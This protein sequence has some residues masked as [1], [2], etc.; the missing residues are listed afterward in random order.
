MSTI[1]SFE[2]I[3]SWQKA[4][5]LNK[6]IYLLSGKDMFNKDYALKDQI[7]RASI[8][9]LS[10]IAEGFERN[11][12][13]EFKQYLSIAKGSAGEVTAQLY[14]AYDLNYIS[15]EEF[16]ALLKKT[17]E[18]SKMI[19]GFIKYLKTSSLTGSKHKINSNLTLNS[20]AKT[21]NPKL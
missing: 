2:D 14:I 6:E 15:N 5:E 20:E 16:Q 1:E 10:N 13:K 3:I 9:I 11:G 4:R 21:Q 12:N 18:L 8:S 19:G 7:R 17:K